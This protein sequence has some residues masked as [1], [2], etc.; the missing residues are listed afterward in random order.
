MNKPE[1]SNAQGTDARK[2]IMSHSHARQAATAAA[3]GA[4]A[5]GAGGAVGYATTLP[6]DP[7][8]AAEEEAPAEAPAQQEPE[9]RV[10]ERVVVHE[11]PAP[12]P[13]EET[14]ED[15]VYDVDN[16]DVQ[17]L[18]V[19]QTGQG[20]YY[21]TAAVDGHA[22]VYVDA[23]GDGQVDVLG[24]D[25][26]N[27]GA[28]EDNEV[29]DVS[30]RNISMYDLATSAQGAQTAA[31]TSQTAAGQAGATTVA[32]HTD[33]DP[34][35]IDPREIEVGHVEHNIDMDGHTVD[36][37]AID[38]RSHAGVAID[39]D[40]DGQADIVAIDL[41]DNQR[42]E[43]N[44]YFDANGAGISLDSPQEPAGSYDVADMTGT[45]ELPDYTNDANVGEYII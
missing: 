26:N 38:Y 32:E 5:M 16:A 20:G 37:A 29:I 44:E 28:L 13:A 41:N 22:A 10:V 36:A 9:V 15:I 4:G 45:D 3:I 11:Q 6:A 31:G 39:T 12:Q 33:T 27:N 43:E 23:D 35:Q 21:A 14:H 25:V 7:E 19:G 1:K 40:R 24:I 17:V 30:G 18:E 34:T 2:N 8:P 42:F